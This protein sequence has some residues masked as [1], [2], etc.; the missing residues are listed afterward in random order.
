MELL[1]GFEGPVWLLTLTVT[2]TL[3]RT[4]LNRQ[5]SRV[6]DR[7]FIPVVLRNRADSP[8]IVIV[9]SGAVEAFRKDGKFI[10]KDLCV[11]SRWELLFSGWRI[12][13]GN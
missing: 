6:E 10:C 4:L 5:W 8:P 12:S 1:T 11:T 3:R 9:R 13:G 2:V 7:F